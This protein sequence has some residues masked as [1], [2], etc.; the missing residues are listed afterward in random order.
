MLN[1]VDASLYLVISRSDCRGQNIFHVLEQAVQGGVTLVQLRE[2]EMPTRDL[3]A[4]AKEMKAF[5]ARHSIPLIINDRVGVALAVGADGVHVGQ[6]DMHPLDVRPLIGP[7]RVLGLSINTEEQLREARSLPVDYL[8]LGP[9]FP[10]QTKK[11]CKP[12]LGLKGLAAMCR[13]KHLPAVGIGG[14]TARNAAQVMAAGAE[15]IAVVS[16]ICGANSPM[17]AAAELKRLTAE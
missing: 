1:F 5:L 7:N 15:G 8:G 16:A 10:T 9:I 3:V 17:D 12:A 11:D 4:L 14:I 13:K 2:K 6:D